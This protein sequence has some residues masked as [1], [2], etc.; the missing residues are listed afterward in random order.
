MLRQLRIATALSEEALAEHAGVSVRA[1]SNLERGVHRTPRLETVR[2]LA[3]ALRLD[4][5]ERAALIAA[6]HPD[7]A[8]VTLP[9][10]E[11]APSSATV[12]L[13]LTRLIGREHEVSILCDV[14]TASDYRLVTLTGPGSVGKT[15]LA[16]AVAA[17]LTER[18][19]DGVWIVELAPLA[20]A[21]LL[22]AA[23][24]QVLGVRAH[25]SQPLIEVLAT[26]LRAKSLLLVVDNFEHLVHGTPFV[27]QLLRAAPNV[28]VLAT[29]RAPL[30]LH[31]EREVPVAPLAVPDLVRHEPVERVLQY[32]AVRLF[33]ARAQD[34][35]PGFTLT[36][37]TAPEVAG[38]CARV[39]GLP[40]AIE[41][42]A[43]RVRLLPL[44]ALLSRLERR[45]PLLT[46]GARDAPARH[47][48][49][50]DTIAW[51]YA[52]LTASA[53]QLFRRLTVFTGGISL[54]AAEQI[55][56][57]EGDLDVLSGLAA[58]V[59]ESLLRQTP[60]PLGEPRYL[61]LETV[62]EFGLD[63]LSAAGEETELRARH[64]AWFGQ[65]ALATEQAIHGPEQTTALDR[66]DLERD[67]LRTAF[68]GMLDRADVTAAFRLAT[69]LSSF[70]EVRGTPREHRAWLERVLERFPS[71]PATLRAEARFYL[72]WLLAMEGDLPAA[73]RT[74]AQAV[75]EWHGYDVP[76]YEV[77]RLFG[78]AHFAMLRGEWEQAA[79]LFDATRGELQG[80]G[81]PLTPL[82]LT[83]RANV[84][85]RRGIVTEV[86]ICL[87]KR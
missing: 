42:A 56:N 3:D 9:L 60:T 58:L 25:G 2:L 69:G 84:E 37:E 52:L 71:A 18:F 12:P 28:K 29:S 14:L 34:A 21:A 62:R 48:T 6:A 10:A 63:A 77:W 32:D 86:A 31:G 66:L 43:A 30:R 76:F 65:W 22:P 74:F 50:R 75:V 27:T 44:A 46:G 24:A 82:V 13:P 39:D 11:P 53:Q 54:E 47:Q 41:L 17:Q 55:A 85:R 79:E 26:Y 15:R 49:L 16:L 72:F 67:N 5:A 59:D 38:I 19:A 83:S 35:V 80:I 4:A 81:G 1:V 8:V 73:T 51:S 61:M 68:A 64:A 36:K 33:V 7:P 40:L 78:L 20:D 57:L 87:K 70:W 45:L 23:I